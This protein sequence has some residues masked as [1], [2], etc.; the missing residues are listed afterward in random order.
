M[1]TLK[2]FAPGPARQDLE[3]A[4]WKDMEDE[5][6]PQTDFALAMA[7]EQRAEDTQEQQVIASNAGHT[8][9]CHSVV[10]DYLTSKRPKW[11]LPFSLC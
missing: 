4:K 3:I 11:R 1:N 8:L 6:V 5:F 7:Q 9:V 2:V 10:L